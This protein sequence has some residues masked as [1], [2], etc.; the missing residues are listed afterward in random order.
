ME[1]SKSTKKSRILSFVEKRGNALPHPAS[2]FGILALIVLLLSVIGYYLGW[3]ALH[4][5]TG[6]TINT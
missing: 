6:E 1:I 5:A 2:L 4:P 3:N